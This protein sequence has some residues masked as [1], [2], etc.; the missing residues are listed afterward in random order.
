MRFAFALLLLPL[1]AAPAFAQASNGAPNFQGGAAFN[2]MTAADAAR[3]NQAV[4]ND[5]QAR[6]AVD[7]VQKSLN[8]AGHRSGQLLEKTR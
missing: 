2:S 1:L 4:N 6:Q 7:Q 3:I 8:D 5:P